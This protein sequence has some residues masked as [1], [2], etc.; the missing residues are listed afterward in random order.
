[1]MSD[2]R[3]FFGKSLKEIDRDVFSLVDAEIFRQNNKIILIPSESICPLPVRQALESPFT[4]VYAEGYPQR[5]LDDEDEHLLE[6]L[7]RILVN[8]W[9]YSDRRF[10]RG[11]EYV[12]FIEALAKK[13]AASLFATA[14][15]P[16]ENIY[17][18][19]QPLSGSAANIAV[20][21]ALLSPGDVIM[22]MSLMHGGHLTH[23]SEFNRS[24]KVYRVIS[25]EVDEKTERLDYNRINDL[26]EQHKPKIIVAGYTSYPWAP[27]W[28]RF[29]EIADNVGA[30]LFADISHPAGLVVAGVY[31]NPMDYADVITF[32]THKTLFGPRGAVIMTTN[33]DFAERIERSVFPGEQG[34]P[35]V[36]KF[37]AMAVAFKMAKSKEFKETQK[38]IVEN[39]KML[40]NAIQENGIKLAYGGTNTH[41]FVLD[42]KSIAT[43]TGFQLKGEIGVRIL[44]LCGVVANKNTIPG[45]TATPEATGI[46]MG[47]PWITQR[48]ITEPQLL[49][50]ADI[51]SGVLKNIK[52]FMYVGIDGA[53]P[54][55]KIDIDIL[56]D[57]INR[58][59]K[60][61]CSLGVETNSERLYSYPHNLLFN[62]SDSQNFSKQNTQLFSV[63]YI[64]GDR[65]IQFLEESSTN[66][67]SCSSER[68]P[69]VTLFLD[70]DGKVISKAVVL[71]V[72]T[73]KGQI[74]FIVLVNPEKKQKI[75]NWF[76]G[77]SDG[78]ITFNDDDI[79]MKVEGPVIVHHYDELDEVIKKEVDKVLKENRE[80]I[81][82]VDFKDVP[83]IENWESIKE[84]I[85]IT[86]PFFIG[87]NI[88]LNRFFKDLF[89]TRIPELHEKSS[90][91]ISSSSRIIH[92][93]RSLSDSG[94]EHEPQLATEFYVSSGAQDFSGSE[95][96]G[97]RDQG[98]I[99]GRVL[100]KKLFVYQREQKEARKSVLYEEHKK[101]GAVMTEFA[102]YRMPL[103]Y[104]SIIEEHN[105]VRN[106]A[107]IFDL[108]HMG[109]VEISGDWATIFL[110]TVTTN[111]VAWLKP[112]E[113]HYSYLL[114]TD[115]NVI[116]DIMV[117]CIA[118][119]RYIIVVNAVNEEKDLLWLAGVN[120]GRYVIDQKYP[121]KEIIN[122]AR[123]VNLK[124]SEAG[125]RAKINLAVQG[126]ASLEVLNSV[127]DD[128]AEKSKL[129]R[130]QKNQ[131]IHVHLGGIE[132]IV[133][134]TGYTGEEFG[135]EIF[136]HP[137]NASRLWNLILARG[138][139][140]GIRP[141][142]LGA[143][144]SLRIEAGLPLY[145]HELAG[146]HGISPEEAGFAPYVKFH[147]PFFVGR[148][149]LL[150][151]LGKSKMSVV[152]FRVLAKGAK[153]ARAGD[154]I[155][156]KRTQRSVG[157]VTSCAVNGQ[158]IQVGLGYVSKGSAEPGTEI[159]I[160]PA[161]VTEI[162]LSGIEGEKVPL[163]IDA[164][165]VPRFLDKDGIQ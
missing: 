81:N 65:A 75:L 48:G 35:H 11:C 44:D 72:N 97:S 165:I 30:L 63:I 98:V 150:E 42:L 159:S 124:S 56:Q 105:T 88:I 106:A 115:G 135:Y 92:E 129:K 120:N 147:K 99:A 12:N 90:A 36:N 68:K 136:V 1:V 89:G 4:S 138:R 103:R 110:D 45:D 55:G 158:G 77:L 25:Y 51:I 74:G 50:L 15:N 154:I 149:A 80:S 122:R 41:L 52:P 34:G 112:G 61:V 126:P 40:A 3:N 130:L 94:S 84:Y 85:D 96:R 108:S 116:D 39:A 114:D 17:V 23:G 8:F 91:G 123:I 142:G 76:R 54:R 28:R 156:D 111:Y 7:G 132:V 9:R 144:D 152:R 161:S 87:Q 133:S 21:D 70:K 69:V 22:G 79:F 118:R 137:E 38:K 10:Y 26:A 66:R 100:N 14:K 125:D 83:N 153:M 59:H 139:P 151:K 73:P 145:G 2:Y 163:P 104:G 43:K 5:S 24:G 102:G 37:A 107:G 160:L 101:L 127:I 27:D 64:A 134:R 140:Y 47:T 148:D 16:P 6:N 119:D 67:I 29:R 143:R 121:F 32:T 31:P 95:E 157:W 162:K 164:R 46:R 13:R 57:A 71:R 117:Y 82:G 33:P 18:N 53:L 58:V 93:R 141:I 128:I 60:L 49:E 146:P 109:L 62:V 19:V 78:Y 131:F 155:I 113:S 86:K 20:Y